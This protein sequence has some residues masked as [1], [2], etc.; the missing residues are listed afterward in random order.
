MEKR[1]LAID[2]EPGLTRLVKSFLE[3]D[4]RFQVREENSPLLAVAAAREFQPD[5]IILDVNMPRM[6]G[7]TVASQ[8]REI[9]EL[10]AVPIVFLTGTVSRGE[11]GEGCASIGGRRFM[12]KPVSGKGL[13][14]T[15]GNV[16]GWPAAEE[17]PRAQTVWARSGLGG[18]LQ[19]WLRL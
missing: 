10:R 1:V 8:I 2:D 15:V 17:T 7:G 5:L 12:A 6:D 9:P 3:T 11:V 19:A 4:G 16:L 13:I 18:K 14:E